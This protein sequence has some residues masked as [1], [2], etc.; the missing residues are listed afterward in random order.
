MPPS[1]SPSALASTVN[2]DAP[3]P[4]L[5]ALSRSALRCALTRAV[6][7][8][9]QRGPHAA[10]GNERLDSPTW[11]WAPDERGH[12]RDAEAKRAALGGPARAGKR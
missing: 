5:A 2:G 8:S 3:E 11:E 10:V 6:A 4:L 7:A 9:C 1:A 12:A